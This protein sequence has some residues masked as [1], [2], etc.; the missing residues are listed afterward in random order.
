MKLKTVLLTCVI[1]ALAAG[2]AASQNVAWTQAVPPLK[3]IDNTY[4]VG[5]ADLAAIL[6][7][8]PAGHILLDV[9][10]PQNAG[11]VKKNIEALGFKVNDIKVLLN[12]HAHFDHSGGLAKL[13]AD[14]G[15]R[16]IASEGDTYALEKGV[17]PGSET[18][19]NLNFPPVK[20]DRQ[21]KDG[22]T[23]TLG[24]VTLT[25]NITP[26]HSRGCTTWT[27]PVKDGARTLTAGA[28]CSASVAANRVT[29]A[30]L[31]YPGIVADYRSTFAKAKTM[32]IDVFLAAHGSFF[33]LA[34][35][36]ARIAPGAPNPF[37]DPAGFQ[38]LIASQERAFEQTQGAAR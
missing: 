5:S 35:K 25:A 26:G 7:T 33:D 18:Q 10:V 4:W 8:T 12:T 23:V 30:N 24:G 29:G 38:R 31:Q 32:K 36:R 15:A 20:V 17:Y 21:V 1:G 11:L 2:P 6:I 16:M 9:G 3:I 37:I 27:W 28:F 14:T 34:G 19:A 22:D 13:K